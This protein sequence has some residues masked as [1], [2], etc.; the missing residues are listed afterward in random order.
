MVRLVLQ[1]KNTRSGK[2]MLPY[3]RSL[4]EVINTSGPDGIRAYLS[5]QT[6]GFNEP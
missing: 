2:N 5:H 4:V 6:L 1:D 3:I